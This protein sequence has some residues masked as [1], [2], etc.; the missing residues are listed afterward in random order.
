MTILPYRDERY[1]VDLCDRIIGWQARRHATFE[2][3]RGDAGPR[4]RGRR[5]PVDAYWAE[6]GLIVEYRERQHSQA[7]PLFDQPGRKTLSGTM[8]SWGATP[9]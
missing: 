3:L 5:L 1:I 8:T 7:I 9:P 6:L 4:S 2:F